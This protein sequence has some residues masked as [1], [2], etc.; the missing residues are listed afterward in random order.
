MHYD[1]ELHIVH[2]NYEQTELAVIG[3]FF[4]VDEGGDEENDFIKSLSL[5]KING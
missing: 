1:L 5:N 4:D 3:I 2:S